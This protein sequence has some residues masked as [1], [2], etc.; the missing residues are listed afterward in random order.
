MK[1]ALQVTF[2][3][4]MALSIVGAVQAHDA[5]IGRTALL[6]TGTYSKV[7]NDGLSYGDLLLAPSNTPATPGDGFRRSTMI[8]PDWEY[9]FGIG[10]THRF[11]CSNTRLFVYYDHFRGDDNAAT[12]GVRNLGLVP[13]AITN[14]SMDVETSSDELRVGLSRGLNFGHHFSLD[15]GGFFEWD[16]IERNTEERNSL[17]GS[18]NRFRSTENEIQ[19]FG[20]GVAVM[21]RAFPSHDYRHF[22]VFMGAMTT[23]LYVNNEFDQNFQIG[24]TLFAH[25]QPDD[26]KSMVGKLDISFGIDYCSRIHTDHTGLAVGM[27]LGMRY[28]NIFNA[29]KNGNSMYNSAIQQGVVNGALVGTPAYTGGSN[30]FGRIGPFIQFRVGGAES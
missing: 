1:K 9:D 18:P 17:V 11:A 24:D 23:L 19:G 13:G 6:L 10:L 3:A 8:D 20:P 26:S 7:T 5:T 16:K 27:S 12:P 15:L 29:F 4:V 25:Y 21:A 22:S 30:D 14:G 28:M 2:G